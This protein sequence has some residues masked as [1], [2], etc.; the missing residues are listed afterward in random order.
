V[1]KA[2]YFPKTSFF[3]AKETSRMSFTWRNI[4]Q[5]KW[6]LTKGRWTIGN[7]ESTR[8]W[9]D[10]WLENQNGMRL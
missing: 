2:K 3:A 4:L 6:I 8:I 7:G 9:E 1:F 10:N 5:S